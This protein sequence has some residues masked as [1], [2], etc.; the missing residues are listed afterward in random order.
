MINELPLEEYLY[1]VIPSEMPTFYGLEALRVQAVCARSYAYKHLMANSLSVYGA[2]V[3]DSVSY[4][5][6]NNISENEDSVLAVKDTYGKVLK[7]EGEVITAYYFST[8]CGHTSEAAN[9]WANNT[10]YPYLVGKV[11]A[12]SGEGE[13]AETQSEF[14]DKYADLS[15]EEVFRSFIEDKELTTYDS[16]FNWYRWKVTI[17]AKELQKVI[18]EN[19]SKRYLA[20]PELILT[21][22]GE[23]EAGEDIF[24]SR[25]VD[26]L[27]RIVDISA[28][29]RESSG[30]IS[31]LLI[32]GTKY[33][34]KIRTEYNIRALL[35]PFYD[36]VVRQDES[37]VKNLN[38]LP[39]A[40]FAIDQE[41]KD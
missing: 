29:K 37:E 21:K 4:Q 24:E 27:G 11:L 19:L 6:Y 23:N 18:E 39:S 38:L 20:N 25:P 35:A 22:T 3:D 26:N 12:V 28:L 10:N 2:H 7:Y 41:K 15:S 9:V 33:T 34:V 16:S 32:E 1:A 36:T 40:F 5:V 13:G 31:E 8:S 17:K 30:I 14:E